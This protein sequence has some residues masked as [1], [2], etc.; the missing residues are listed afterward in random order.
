ML[1]GTDAGETDPVEVIRIAPED[2]TSI[3]DERGSGFTQRKT[4]GWKYSHFGA[5]LDGDWRRNDIMFGRLDA[6]E[7][8]INALVPAE[9]QDRTVLLQRAQRAILLESLSPEQQATILGPEPPSQLSDKEILGRFTDHYRVA[10]SLPP[11]VALPTAARGVEVT[12]RVLKG[13]SAETGAAKSPIGWFARIGSLI[14]GLVAVATPG[15]PKS[16][17]FRHLAPLLVLFELV[18]MGLGW[19]FH[20]P[21]VLHLGVVALIVTLLVGALVYALSSLMR[22]R[23]W[24]IPA[25]KGIVLG[26]ILLAIVGI[27]VLAA[28]DVG[29][30]WHHPKGV[31]DD[32][33]TLYHN[34][35]GS[36]SPSP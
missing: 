18:M 17:V 1:Y 2:A 15:S 5:F 14:A 7:C 8:L 9:N 36:P 29:R 27:L 31:W 16:L 26:L 20:S 22:G 30:N 33:V 19:L 34:V 11:A 23:R 21:A 24:P 13:I 4:R 35:H 12:G 6:A 32:L 28:A 10:E 25:L 3:V